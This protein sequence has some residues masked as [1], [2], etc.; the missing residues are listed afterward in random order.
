MP[1][2][3][4]GLAADVSPQAIVFFRFGGCS[5]GSGVVWGIILGSSIGATKGDTRNFDYSHVR[6]LLGLCWGNGL[7][8]PPQTVTQPPKHD[9]FPV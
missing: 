3:S 7:G 9:L 1:G 6:A 4:K 8:V 2:G 5:K